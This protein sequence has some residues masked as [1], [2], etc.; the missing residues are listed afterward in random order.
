MQ[1]AH[2]VAK[3]T[4]ILYIRMAITIFISLYSTRLILAALGVKDFGLFNVVGG[5]IAMLGFLNASMQGS[6]QR[7]MSF[8]QGAGDSHKVNKIFNMSVL[9]HIIIALVIFFVLQIVGYFLFHGILNIDPNR[10]HTA[11]MVYQFMIVSTLFTVVSVPYDALINSHENMMFY[12]IVS[13]IEAI[14]KLGIALFLGYVAGDK[15]W[16]YGLLMASLSIM[17]LII[18]RVYC[19]YKYPESK[20]DIVGQYD[21]ILLKEMSSFAGW[22]LLG[23]SSSMITNYGQGILMN[24]F[25]GTTVNAAQGVANQVCGQLGAF[26]S[27]MSRALNPVIAKSEGGGNRQL[28]IKASMMGSKFLFLLILFFYVPVFIEMPY[29]FKIWLKTPPSYA[30]VFCRLL[31]IKIAFEQLYLTMGGIIS[32]I[33]KIRNFQIISSIISYSPLFISYFLFKSYNEPSIIYYVYIIY[34]MVNGIVVIYFVNINSGLSITLF[35]KKVVLKS[36][37]SLV[38]ISAISVLPLYVL[39]EGLL[40]F[41]SVISLSSLSFCSVV[42]YI[43]IDQNEKSALQEIIKVALLKFKKN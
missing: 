5:A 41:L 16:Y 10:L 25:F 18:N 11:K 7:F 35:L 28:M 36:V 34:A 31:M 3:N 29:I 4:G 19:Y 8:A 40:R 1:A 23:S 26:A 22:S 38:V 21:T 2:R 33:G 42:W 14:S 20:I 24:V 9:L 30:V 6:T 27:T 39:D 43:G 17:V 32:A 37:L 13:L 15:L 12:A